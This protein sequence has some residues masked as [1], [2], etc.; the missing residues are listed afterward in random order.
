MT[1]MQRVLRAID[2]RT[3][4]DDA[5]LVRATQLD[6]TVLSLLLDKLDRM[7]LIRET[8]VDTWVVTRMGDEVLGARA[9]QVEPA[10]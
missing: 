5:A 2:G 10:E 4:M 7:D 8:N 6:E 3:N 9:A 1:P